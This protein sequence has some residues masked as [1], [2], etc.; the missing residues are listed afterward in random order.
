MNSLMYISLYIPFDLSIIA[1]RPMKSLVG[2]FDLLVDSLS[3]LLN[4]N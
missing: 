3:Q 1:T 2:S 4:I